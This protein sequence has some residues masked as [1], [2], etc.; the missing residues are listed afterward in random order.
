M[1]IFH[2]IGVI[3]WRCIVFIVVLFLAL[4]GMRE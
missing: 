4:L 1:I 2:V 3:L